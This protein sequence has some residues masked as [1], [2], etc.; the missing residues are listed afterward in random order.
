MIPFSECTDCTVNYRCPFFS[1]VVPKVDTRE[2]HH[3]IKL[4][5]L[6][7]VSGVPGKYQRKLLKDFVVDDSN[8]YIYDILQSIVASW[9]PHTVNNYFNYIFN[10][11]GYG[12]GKTHSACTLLNEFIIKEYGLYD[13]ETPVSMYVDFSSLMDRIRSNIEHPDE[14]LHNYLT[15]I[16]QC[17]LLVVDDVGAARITDYV[18]DRAFVIFNERY[19]NNRSTIVCSNYNLDYLNQ[20]VALTGRIISRLRENGEVISFT[21]KD[22]RV[23]NV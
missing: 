5:M 7:N 1:G 18:R 8:K 19:M 9:K 13:M 2:C 11:P 21:G 23:F 15:H 6:F 22:R 3:K 4:D 20:D 16:S 12:T 10:G 17:N 14:E